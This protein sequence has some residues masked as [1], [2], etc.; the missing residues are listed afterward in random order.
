MSS[1]GRTIRELASAL[2]AGTTTP[3][4]LLAET[5]AHQRRVEPHLH[6]FLAET[7]ELAEQQAEAAGRLLAERPHAASP[8]TTGPCDGGTSGMQRSGGVSLTPDPSHT[9]HPARIAF[10]ANTGV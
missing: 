3:G 10:I 5:R 1:T 4:Q 9:Q 7:N 8:L 6:A 2:R